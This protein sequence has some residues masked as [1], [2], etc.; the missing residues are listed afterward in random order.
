MARQQ[1]PEIAE[2]SPQA[3][4]SKTL[5][6]RVAGYLDANDWNYTAC[7][8]KTYFSMGY[9]IKDGSLRIIVDVFEVDSFQRVLVYSSFPVF[10]P[11]HRRTAAA[12]SLTRINYTTIFGNFEMDLKDGEVR[13]RTVLETDGEISDAMIC[14]VLGANI[15][16]ADRYFAPLLTVAFG[17]AKPETVLD[18]VTR[19]D[20]TTLQ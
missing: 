10:I 17:N 5:F 11:E 8:E 4:P 13:V 19:S 14:H 12:E 9:R 20:E 7:E 1:K 2:N 15:D 3:A 16:A 6:E 18:L